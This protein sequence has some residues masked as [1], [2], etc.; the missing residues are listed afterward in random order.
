MNWLQ[1]LSWRFEGTPNPWAASA[2]RYRPGD[3]PPEVEMLPSGEVYYP[4]YQDPDYPFVFLGGADK[5]EFAM[6]EKMAGRPIKDRVSL[7]LRTDEDLPGREILN[8]PIEEIPIF[9]VQPGQV[10][11]PQAKKAIE[12]FKMAVNVLANIIHHRAQLP[13][14]KQEPIYIHCNLG[15]NRSPAVLAAVLAA[16][17]GKP[18]DDVLKD[19]ASQRSLIRPSDFNY[20]L[21]SGAD[22]QIADEL[23][24]GY[25]GY[26][27]ED[28]E[29][30]PKPPFS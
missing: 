23:D 2:A 4:I 30:S 21:A 5:Y 12:S 3:A 15:Q 29:S 20:W 17:K 14:E 10:T 26:R 1:K 6:A 19:I 27:S 9:D 8:V 28:P 11:D 22:P 25:S 7:A 18:V 16:L 24:L 13:P